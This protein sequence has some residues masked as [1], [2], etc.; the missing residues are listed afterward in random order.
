MAAI[1]DS[2]GTTHII[3]LCP[4]LYDQTLQPKENEIMGTI[5]DREFRRE[6]TLD[7]QKRLAE[8]KAPAGKKDKEESGEQIE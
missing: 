3:G 7:V 6:K 2:E 4:A 1:G 8:K 5:F